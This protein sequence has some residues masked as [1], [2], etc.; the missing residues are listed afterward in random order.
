MRGIFD[1]YGRVLFKGDKVRGVLK[2]L[3]MYQLRYESTHLMGFT[4]IYT[5]PYPLTHYLDLG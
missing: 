2:S 5:L 3:C 1:S 4:L